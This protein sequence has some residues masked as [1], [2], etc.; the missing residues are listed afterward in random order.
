MKLRYIP[1]SKQND[2]KDLLR[3]TV[4]LFSKI[5]FDS[6]IT[7]CQLLFYYEKALSSNT[8][9]A[10]PTA[11]FQHMNP[12]RNTVQANNYTPMRSR[13][14]QGRSLRN[15]VAHRTA[16]EILGLGQ[17]NIPASCSLDVEIERY[18]NDTSVGMSSIQYWQVQ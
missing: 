11:A 7:S 16:D 17:V 4:C 14:I 1:I 13:A 3:Q 12:S 2:A 6:L 10:G 15:S 18:L 5:F 8:T 9:A